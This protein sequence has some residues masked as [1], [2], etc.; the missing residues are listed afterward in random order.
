[1]GGATGAEARAA[2]AAA[3]WRRNGVIASGKF[4]RIRIVISVDEE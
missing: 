1:V 3:S 2:W 4:R